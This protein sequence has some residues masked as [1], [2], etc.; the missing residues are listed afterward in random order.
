MFSDMTFGA[1]I[2][3]CIFCLTYVAGFAFVRFIDKAI[4][5]S[6]RDT[7]TWPHWATLVPIWLCSPVV[8][9]RTIVW[10]AVTFIRMV[11]RNLNGIRSGRAEQ[12]S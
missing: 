5:E 1:K 12:P 9:I 3:W 11:R 8:I 4:A 10:V 7:A 6:G 2:F